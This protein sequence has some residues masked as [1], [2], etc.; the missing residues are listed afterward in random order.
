VVENTPSAGQPAA[1]AAEEQR[2]LNAILRISLEDI[3]LP[4]QF[5]RVLD[6][7]LALSWLPIEP[8]G[9]IF[10]VETGQEVLRLVAQRG[11]HPA[12]LTAC[13]R[14]PFGHC[15]CGRAAATGEIQF[16]ACL[17]DRHEIS[18]TGIQPHGHYNVPIISQ[19]V[20][21]GVIVLYLK[22]GHRQQAREQEFLA[23]VAATLAGII[24]RSTIQDALRASEARLTEAQRI[25]RLGG[26]E[27]EAGNDR[28]TLSDGAAG[29]LGLAVHDGRLT[30]H[31][32]LERLHPDDRSKAQQAIDDAVANGTTF[33][34]DYR[35]RRADGS[36][37]YVYGRAEATHDRESRALRLAGTVQDITARKQM[38]ERLRQSATVFENTTEGVII[39]DAAG[40]I[41]AV[42]R[43]CTQITGYSEQELIGQPLAVLRSGR[44]EADFYDAM[45]RDV[46]ASGSWQGEVWS[47]RKSGDIYPEWLN[48]SV[49][50][51]EQGHI[52][53]FVNVFSDISAMKESESRLDHL[54]HHDPLTGLPNRLLLMAR[55]EQS[56]AR[57]RR[58]NTLLAVLFIDLDRFKDINDTLGHPV[59][60]LLLQA[61]A[62]RL[63]ECVREEDTVSRLGGDE[64]TV[65]IEELHD[66]SAAGTVAQKIIVALAQP[67]VLQGHEVFITASIGI[68]LFPDDGADVTTLLKNSDSALYRAK[69]QG[70]DNYHY[71]TEELTTRA[72][73]RLA[74]E[75]DMRH[76][77]ERNELVVHY[78]PQ[79]DLYSGHII[80]MEALLRWQH[81][82]RGL[83]PPGDFIPLAEDTGLILPIGE[84]V[85]RTA[86]ERVQS[87]VDQGLQPVRVAVN[88]SS[89]QFNQHDLAETVK[90]ILRETRL[91]PQYL[92]LELTERLIMQDAEHAIIILQELK[93]LGVQFSIDDFGTGYSSLSYL[94][95]FPID[96]IKID[97]SFVRNI[98]SDPEDAAVSQAIISMSHSLNLKTVAEGV[99]TLE[100][101]EFLRA[102]QCD[103][104]QGFYF[105]R[106]VPEQE[107]EQMLRDG[108][109]LTQTQ[110]ELPREERVLLLVDDDNHVLDA[111]IHALHP[112]G[113]RILHT[114]DPKEALN[115]LATHHVGV[116]VSDQMMPEM[117][118]IE[119][120]RKVRQLH[121][122]TVRIM[123]TGYSDSR[124]ITDAINEGAVYKFISKPWRNDLL[125][126]L[127]REAFVM[128]NSLLAKHG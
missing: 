123:L 70:R 26:W 79:V 104:M 85:L 45:W 57:A 1:E 103:E 88:L 114:T 89:R 110:P 124:L 82:Q 102:R 48:I 99:E 87:W 74:L 119:L 63:A 113:Y 98:T 47:R 109:K 95:K 42:N 100:Q 127:L 91:D 13:A 120:L 14:V 86:C 6:I 30:L 108:V 29:I 72:M 125:R 61:V 97:Q 81:P 71:Y 121:P 49:V 33:D 128:H 35:I 106:A 51:D 28:L 21:L 101:Q 66:S 32:W 83:I 80:G 111:L 90:R 39:T 56:L 73:V 19:R 22:H 43:A 67:L 7:L 2:A 126:E 36:E 116:I 92:E 68:A 20:V 52:T 58:N 12:L 112:D 38:E 107:M 55:M 94:K 46:L 11:L 5:E 18:Y 10:L 9:G 62:L 96:R 34:M 54:A 69:E 37:C 3:P 115:L 8:V 23:S 122:D 75:T 78:Q 64:F 118:G 4:R 44:H 24:E 93:A 16:A 76:A 65:L 117:N 31:D 59:G 50:K 77:I 60:D 27:W 40:H 53:H 84:W 25:A 41:T 105:S 15:L 17:D